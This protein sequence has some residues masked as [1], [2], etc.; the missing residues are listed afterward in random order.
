[1]IAGILYKN[2]E[3]T[4][5]KED[6]I[7]LLKQ[8]TNDTSSIEIV[9]NKN[10]GMG[11]A[12]DNVQTMDRATNLW[13]NN[14]DTVTV[15]FSGH[16]YNQNK[17]PEI[18]NGNMPMGRVLYERFKEAGVDLFDQ[19]NGNYALCLWNSETQQFFLTRDHLGVEPLYYFENDELI[20]FA[21]SMDVLLRHPEIK[22]EIDFEAAY[23]YLLF[24]YNPGTNTF[25]RG[26]KKLRPGYYFKFANG[27]GQTER[28][29]F[30]SF[31]ADK[32][33]QEEEYVAELLPMMREAVKIRLEQSDSHGAFLS[34]GM[35]SSSI[36]GL[37]SPI[38]KGDVHTFSF[39]CRG[40]SFD[41]SH[42]AQIVSDRYGTKHHLVEYSPQE[43]LSI[44]EIVSLMDEPFSDIG[45]EVASYILGKEAQGKT[46]YVLTGDGG[47]ELFAGHPVYQ[48]DQ[49]AQKF[50]R[51]PVAVQKMFTSIFR[52][53][54]DTEKKK[55]F[56]VKAQRFAY[57]Y[58]FPEE[59]FSNRWRI[60]Y[61]DKEFKQLLK[62]DLHDELTHADPL[63]E[64]IS[65][66]KEADG[67]DFL[68]KTLYGDYHTVVSFYLRRMQLLRAF[69]IEGRFPM[70]DP[71]LVEYAAKIP[72]DLKLR[73][74]ETK[75]ILHKTMTGVLPD[76]IVFRKDKLGHSVPFKNWLRDQQ[77]IKSFVTDVLSEETVR[78]RGLFNYKFVSDL[79]EEHFKR[80]KN[81]S[82][83]IWA[84]LVLE[85]WMQKHLD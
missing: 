28:Y 9:V 30:L 22:A 65:I 38:V 24:N 53:F 42:Y 61:T 84:L 35:D 18:D 33:L 52:L 70:F 12:S 15:L 67:G 36:V 21:S 10:L 60:Y 1:M 85:L 6:V 82:H 59:L 46:N 55:S 39:R 2:R 50:S 19:I 25:I 49:V 16:V 75:Y 56:A 29:W 45:I 47:D 43:V 54:P 44:E 20:V 57:S 34:G 64:I 31:Q 13:H 41:E 23:R 37:M 79:L 51:L 72:S 40:K 63:G 74:S 76:E 5:E 7:S 83:R 48:A 58:Q 32:I 62:N 8:K 11:F 4:A 27:D 3:R 17:F 80:T 14:N 26:V 77:Q 66:Y 71:R 81:N 78:R 69:G 68:S 73:G